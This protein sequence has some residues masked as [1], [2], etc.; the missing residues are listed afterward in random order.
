M[1]KKIIAASAIFALFAC[2]SD[3]DD[4]PP[5]VGGGSSSSHDDSQSSSSHDGSGNNQSSSSATEI[6]IAEFFTNAAST[7]T[8]G[9]I[10]NFAYGY[11]LKANN[12]E[13]LTQFWHEDCPTEAQDGKP[14]SSCRLTEIQAELAI[15]QNRLTNQYSD[16]HYEIHL[17]NINAIGNRGAIELRQYDLNQT[18]DQ[19]ALG[20]DI[21]N[22][23]PLNGVT[24]FAYTYNGGTHKFRAVTESDTDFWEY[25]VPKTTTPATI[26]ISVN[27][28]VGMGILS[29]EDG[30]DDDVPFD[31][32]RVAKFLWVVEYTEPLSSES[33]KGTI[34]INDFKAQ[35]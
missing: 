33:N 13:D 17:N 2:S 10:K 29:G 25:E 6:E 24:A 34:L 22:T 27:K 1:L 5:T 9:G 35:L 8:F 11:T 30:E 21:A 15:L 7:A 18:G 4:P 26:V 32:S 20:L 19:A 31:I 16:L 28:F 14:D 23:A 3:S 12:A